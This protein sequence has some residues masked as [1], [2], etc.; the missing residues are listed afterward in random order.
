[1]TDLNLKG[2]KICVN[3]LILSWRLLVLLVLIFTLLNN[4]DP[5]RLNN[6]LQV[7]LNNIKTVRS[8]S[9]FFFVKP[10]QQLS[11]FRTM[12]HFTNII[13]G[14]LKIHN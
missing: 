3:L 1:M 8:S 11:Y 6:M 2:A 5:E 9:V 10:S 4:A 14:G 13:V 7:Y 12:N